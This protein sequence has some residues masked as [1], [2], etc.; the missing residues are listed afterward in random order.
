MEAGLG[1]MPEIAGVGCVTLKATPL[2]A[3][4]LPQSAS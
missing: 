3:T 1:V 4:Q 2:L